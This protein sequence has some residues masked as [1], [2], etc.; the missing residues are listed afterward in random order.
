M[1][2]RLLTVLGCLCFGAGW[3]L[4]SWAGGRVS[5]ADSVSRDRTASVPS[6]SA[7]EQGTSENG[8]ARQTAKGA[9]H[10]VDD[11]L[12]LVT[13]HQ[14]TASRVRVE[15]ALAGLSASDLAAFAAVIG[16]KRTNG[17]EFAVEY[18]YELLLL[19]WIQV[20]PVSA[21][22][23]TL[24]ARFPGSE[25]FEAII[26]AMG[27]VFTEDRAAAV[28]IL[29]EMQERELYIYARHRCIDAMKGMSAQDA[30]AL[31]MEIDA[32][33]RN[34]WHGAQALGEFPGEWI[35]SD[36][37]GAMNWALSLPPGFTRREILQVMGSLW[38]AADSGAYQ[39]FMAAVP[40]TT[41]PKGGAR[42]EID[43]AIRR[44]ESRLQEEAKH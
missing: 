31:I 25:T 16:S 39:A 35:K 9:I 18:V 41:L 17:G 29:G 15:R 27:K 7:R 5:S 26:N 36:P 37:A 19:R 6:T 1:N 43:A 12:G 22:E 33:T 40:F 2:P 23:F 8:A 14:T 4:D 32:K 13:R 10:T 30:L 42:N 28:R 3:G 24:K 21:I 44:Q 38:A 20:E 34:E 11:L